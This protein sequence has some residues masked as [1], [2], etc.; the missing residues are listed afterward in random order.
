MVDRELL[1][2]KNDGEGRGG[3]GEIF[4]M[5]LVTTRRREGREEGTRSRQTLRTN[6]YLFPVR[7]LPF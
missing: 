1:K 4:Q 7:R 6:E 5:K 2:L 3:E